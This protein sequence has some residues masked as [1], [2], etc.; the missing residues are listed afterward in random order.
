MPLALVGSEN[1]PPEPRCVVVRTVAEMPAILAMANADIAVLLVL[2]LDKGD[3]QRVADMVIG[4]ASGAAATL[5]W[6]GDSTVVLRSPRAQSP[7]L[8]HH[9]LAGAV[10]HALTAATPRLLTPDDE[11]RLRTQAGA[12]SA[13]ARRRL[14]DAYA[15]VATLVALWLRSPQLSAQSATRYAHEELDALVA[16]PSA[17]PLLVEL[18]NLI[19]AR[20][21]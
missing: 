19:A 20:L 18:V 4:W 7:R 11:R 2:R 6:L 10:E 3:R 21:A 14:I 15:E 9:G 8:I 1:R 16:R 5:D 17:T 12:G 13:A